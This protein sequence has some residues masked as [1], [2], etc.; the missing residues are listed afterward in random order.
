LGPPRFFD[1]F[2]P[3]PTGQFLFASGQFFGKTHHL[4]TMH[5]LQTTD[6]RTQHYSIKARPLVQSAKN[7]SVR[8]NTVAQVFEIRR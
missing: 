7:Y 3:M 5:T 1:K 8:M 4:A 6:R 2:T